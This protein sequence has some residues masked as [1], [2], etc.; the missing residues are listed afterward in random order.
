[1]RQQTRRKKHIRTDLISETPSDVGEEFIVENI[2]YVD[3]EIH[4][5]EFDPTLTA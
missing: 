4:E 3:H 1:M 2:L 5:T